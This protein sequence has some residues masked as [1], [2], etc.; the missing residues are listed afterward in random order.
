[1]GIR[2]VSTAGVLVETRIL[3]FLSAWSANWEE[4]MP[5]RTGLEVSWTWNIF[6]PELSMPMSTIMGSFFVMVGGMMGGEGWVEGWWFGW[7]IAGVAVGGSV[8]IADIV[9]GRGRQIRR[10]LDVDEETEW[11]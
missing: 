5:L 1:M 4:G 8:D 9:I 2:D 7:C 10:G 11:N 3:G 6:L